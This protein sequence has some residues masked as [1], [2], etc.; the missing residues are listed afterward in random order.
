MFRLAVDAPTAGAARLRLSG[1]LDDTAAREVLHAA[2]NVVKCGCS[3]LVV[4]LGGIESYDEEAAYAVVGCAG[5]AR[6]L[7]DGVAVVAGT[8]PGAELADTAGVSAHHDEAH[9]PGTMVSCRA[10]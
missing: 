10:C 5:L 2:A 1:H 6:W 4:D 9:I 3:R 7:P 8:G